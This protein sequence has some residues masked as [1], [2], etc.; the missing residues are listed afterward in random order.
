MHIEVRNAFKLGASAA[1]GVFGL[2]DFVI[3]GLHVLGTR[4]KTAASLLCAAGM[5]QLAVGVIMHKSLPREARSGMVSRTTGTLVSGAAFKVGLPIAQKMVER[6][7]LSP[8]AVV[9]RIV[10]AVVIQQTF[11]WVVGGL[12]AIVV[13]SAM[14]R[15][16]RLLG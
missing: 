9:Q 10:V 14:R 13:W 3:G 12:G 11:S 5:V 8:E 7:G 2:A 1:M 6:M 15:C 4:Q 16:Q